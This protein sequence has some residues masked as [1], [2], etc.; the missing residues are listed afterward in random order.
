MTQ[1]TD[2]R[3]VARLTE[4]FADHER[5]ADPAVAR[6]IAL[7]PQPVRRRPRALV[8]GAAVAAMLVACSALYAIST[9]APK[10]PTVV[11]RTPIDQPPP[12]T[13][14]SNRELA[15]AG[16]ARVLG[17][18]PVPP[19]STR[20]HSAPVARLRHL[21]VQVEPLDPS[22]TRTRWWVVPLSY[23]ALVAWY[24]AHTPANVS[25]A[26]TTGS[27]SPEPQ[28]DL[29][30]LTH[31]RS[32]A[33][34]TPAVAVSYASLGPHSTAIRTDVTLAARYD[35]TAATLAPTS[36]TSIDIT[37]SANDGPL[38]SP[39][40]VTVT[41]PASIARVVSAFNGLRGAYAQAPMACG[42]PV[43][44]VVDYVVAFHWPGHTLAVDPGAPL[45]GIGRALT[46][47]GTKLP[48]TVADG[49][50]LDTALQKAFGDS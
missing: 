17:T 32:A 14:P 20:S 6:Q 18:V 25:S 11:A 27:P 48:Q 12:S 2:E 42:S 39:A 36:V 4:T 21:R 46:L 43:G 15:R 8:L 29:D 30:W 49:A 41:D 7:T 45:C 9:S 28:G 35:R 5:D 16:A 34:S 44:V 3:V 50:P 26:Y 10:E 19:R 40:T 1:W 23:R 31:D 38:R 24:D 22:L 47:D 33:Y 37:T 13:K